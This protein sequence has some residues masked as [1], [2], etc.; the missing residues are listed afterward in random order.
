MATIRPVRGTH[1][2]L[3]DAMRAHRH[4]TKVAA[5]VA[6]TFGFEEIATPIFEFSE[7]FQRT[8]GDASD[9]V[10][11]EMYTLTTKGGES[12][13]LRPENTAGV[14]RACISN[15]LAG[16]GP[17]KFHYAGP[18][19]RHERPQKGRQRQ[20]HQTGIEL[21]GAAQPL[22][23]I[24][25]IAC[26]AAVLK[27]L[28]LMDRVRLEL[29][30]LGDG[31]SRTAYRA[32]LLDYFTAHEHELSADSRA[33][34]QR[35][36][37]RIL[38]SKDDDDRD[39]VAGAP[40]F[41]DFMTRE[42]QDFFATVRDGLVQLDIPFTVNPRLVRGLDY[43]C[44][45]AFEFITDHL[46]AQGAVMA[47]GRYD[48]LVAA[49]GGPD[50]P[51][52]GWAAGVER[53]AM[54]AAAPPPPLRPLM[55]ASL[56]EA[57]ARMSLP[58]LSRLRSIGMRVETGF[59]GNLKKRLQQAAKA[60]AWGVLILGD[61]ELAAGQIRLKLMDDGQHYNL[62]LADLEGAV[63]HHAEASGQAPPHGCIGE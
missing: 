2:L 58:L 23:D 43:Y 13:T 46:G 27:R 45:T 10:M 38:D 54:L 28:G 8:L 33:R 18:M 4:V 31:E 41:D 36:P 34:L 14:A 5:T 57:A 19:F 30:S 35:N 56:G 51:G 61:E 32:A 3:P 29:N 22:A 37:L 26:G 24:E 49:L 63:R 44:H 11:K 1:D 20:F 53:L 60:D 9:V 50:V 39:I 15:G 6:L 59:S 25:V 42:A 40:L 16:Q 21:L 55:L 62:P 52:V 17:A 47:G 7:V 12:I 48:G